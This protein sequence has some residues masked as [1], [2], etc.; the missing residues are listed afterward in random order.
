MSTNSNSITWQSWSRKWGN[1]TTWTQNVTTT[2]APVHRNLRVAPVN[3][4]RQIEKTQTSTK[5]SPHA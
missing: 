1:W 5:I 4:P 2:R 3:L